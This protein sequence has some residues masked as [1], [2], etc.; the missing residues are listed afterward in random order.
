MDCVARAQ[1]ALP[2]RRTVFG[3]RAREGRPVVTM[4][5]IAL[6]LVAYVVLR[7]ADARV[8]LVFVPFAG[9][10]EPYRF[11]SAAFLHGGFLHLAVN[12]YALWIVGSVLE[13]ALGRWRFAALYLVSAV[14]G[15]VG[16]LL[17]ASPYEIEWITPVVGASGAVFGLFGA[18]G[19]ALRRLGR[20]TTQ[21]LV[22]IVINTVIGFTIPNIAWQAH[23][24][25]LVTG[26]LLA[27]AYVY[28]PRSRQ[29]A[30]GVAAT[31]LVALV[32]VALAVAKY[33]I[34]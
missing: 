20:D 27:A 5:I 30:T 8:P 1:S 3:G 29:T 23:L 9:E 6:C 25:G 28:A 14:G 32:V 34:T 11:L 15:S 17:F 21:I 19:L 33:A 13:P 22:L 4:A 31:V 18:V 10:S 26:A 7:A 12:M 16:V 24:G 2:T